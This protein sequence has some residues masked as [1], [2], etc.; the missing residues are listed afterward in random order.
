M[1]RT[2]SDKRLALTTRDLAI[3][4]A[5]A[6]YR[7]LNSVYL[8]AFVGGASETRFKERLGSLFHEGFL[9][10][11][12]KQWGF[13]EARYRPAVYELGSGGRRALLE[14]GRAS[15]PRTYLSREAQRQF[16]HAVMICAAVAS[17]EL[18]AREKPELR[19]I[20]WGEILARAP[21]REGVAPLCLTTG[22][23]TI[24]P[25]ALFGLEYL[26]EG[27]KAYRFFALEA[28]RG[29]M[30]I[31]R[32]DGRQTSMLAK[33]AGYRT[34]IEQGAPKACLGVPNLLVLTVTTSESR[35]TEIMRKLAPESSPL[36]LFKSIAPD[37]TAPQPDL[38]T[39]PW[40]RAGLEDFAIDR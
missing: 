21:V 31:A 2:P 14:S 9:D 28:D 37:G 5:L 40:L 26:N 11:P 18:A 12:E 1:Q 20:P 7:Y 27:R 4:E 13:A 8:H 10:R 29:T 22:N 25:D 3:F 33:L 34:I 30:P 38:L 15:T 36:F 16:Q 23:V 17:I 6:N 35:C 39:A 24:V 32:S 19:F